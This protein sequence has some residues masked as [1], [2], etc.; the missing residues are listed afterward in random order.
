MKLPEDVLRD[1][2]QTSITIAEFSRLEGLLKEVL[3]IIP[4]CLLEMEDVLLSVRL[5]NLQAK[6]TSALED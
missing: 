4:S 2:N 5:L 3:L 1:N 6:I